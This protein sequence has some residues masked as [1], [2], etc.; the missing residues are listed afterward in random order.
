MAEPPA[1]QNT[2]KRYLKKERLQELLERLFPGHT[3]FNIEVRVVSRL[4]CRT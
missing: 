2:I 3:K 4:D 1:P